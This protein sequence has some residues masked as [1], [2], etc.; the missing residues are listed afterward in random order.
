MQNGVGTKMGGLVVVDSY[1]CSVSLLI[2]SQPAGSTLGD[3]QRLCVLCVKIA[4]GICIGALIFI[5][6]QFVIL[7]AMAVAFPALSR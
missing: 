4:L 6:E 3:C 1:L 7:I 5:L 2:H